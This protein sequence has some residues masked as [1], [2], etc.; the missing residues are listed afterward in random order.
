MAALLKKQTTRPMPANAKIVTRKGK[1]IAQW[2][3]RSGKKRTA[4]LTTGR[5][6]STRIKTEA[7]TWTAKYRDGVG[8]I[9]EV[10]TGCRDRQAAAAILK[11]LTDRSEL[12]KAKILSPDQDKVA[13]HQR[14]PVADHI[15]AYIGY[16]RDRGRNAHHVKNYE[17]RLNRSANECNFR[18][19]SDLNADRLEKWLSVLTETPKAATEGEHPEPPKLISAS[20]YNGYID[21]WVAF[22]NWLIGKRVNGHRSNMQGEKRM[23]VNPFGGIGKRDTNQD[24][25]RVARALT[26]DE[27][28]RLL[29]SARERPVIAAETVRRG[30]KKGQRVIVLTDERRAKLE[31]LGAERA[32]I[33]K[34]A[35]LTGLRK[36]ELR[37]MTVGDL[38][39]GDV[40]F[41]KLK[42]G[43][44]KNRQ[45]STLP[46]RSDLA[47]ELRKWTADKSPSDRVFHVSSSLTDILDKDL[48]AAGIP[49]IDDEGR[50]VHVH[51]LRH[52]FGTHLSRAGVTPRVA[53]AAMR[54]SNISLTM[55]TYTDPRLLDTAAAVESL[56]DFDRPRK[57][58]PLV[59]TNSGDGRK[60]GGIAA[61]LDDSADIGKFRRSI[62]K[63]P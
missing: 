53:Q 3:T 54:H 8:V 46:I 59:A 7:A 16:Q 27:M 43:N 12:V 41:V 21:A 14:T 57:V 61:H 45:G 5:D 33:Y 30:P 49:K 56:P 62:K 44:E 31:R 48:E 15:A 23:L 38:S 4:E 39:F 52:S 1:Q 25:R 60:L 22:G 58:A 18:W 26:E 2:K 10:A 47:G 6:G 42:A 40:S 9:R 37:S 20:V 17:T 24:R 29:Q 50:V 55:T 11:E 13:D 32:L 63:T 34:T 51:A 36:G 28:S 35:I 19:L